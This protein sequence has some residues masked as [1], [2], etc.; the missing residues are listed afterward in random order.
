MAIN[1]QHLRSFHAVALDGSITRAARRLSISQPTL[2]QQL[3]ALELRHKV[4]LFESRKQPMQL[5]EAGKQLFALTRKLFVVS[6]EIEGLF[7][8]SSEPDSAEL[9][10][11]SDSPAYAAR[12]LS[13]LL[14][15]QP[16]AR[17]H[18]RIGNA[19]EV[20]LWLKDAQIDAAI[21]SDPPGDDAYDYQLLYRD[22]LS[23]AIPSGHRLAH[24]EQ[25]M[26]TEIADE[27]LLLR[28]PTS[29]T[30]ISTEQWL[31]TGGVQ[32][33]VT[34]EFNSREAIRESIALGLGVS[35]FYSAE[36]PPDRRIVYRQVTSLV[37]APSFTGYV[38]CL[39]ERRRTPMMRLV[40]SIA[41]RLARA[42]PLPL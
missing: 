2:S 42:S 23:L 36:C 14:L 33:G 31:I 30:R 16:K 38:V 1:L 37:P 9:R 10:L 27:R 20:A 25:V 18:V 5:T 32:P 17:A 28:E 12:L 29:R 8:E 15:E 7:G 22:E 40:F 11:G 24:A 26:L 39:L 34:V 13:E 35:F 21:C 4:T 6:G 19:R 3:R 41:E